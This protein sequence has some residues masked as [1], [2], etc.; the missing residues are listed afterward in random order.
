MTKKKPA[1]YAQCWANCLGDC[2]D[3]MS[4]EH[5][6]SKCL[7][8][9]DIK[10][11]GLP[12]CKD[13]EKTMRIETLTSR[14][15]CRYH[16]RSL[17]EVDNAAKHTLD[18]LGAAFELM[19]ARKNIRSRNWTVKYFETNML[20][21]ERWCLKTLININLSNKPGL[22]VDL[23]GKSNRPTEELVRIAFGLERFTPP[24]GLYRV[25][26]SGEKIDLLDGAIRLE[27]QSVNDRLAGAKFELWG[28]PFVLSLY[29]EPI[30]WE[31]CHLIRG[32]LKQWFNTY[33]LKRRPVK[34]HLVTFTY[35]EEVTR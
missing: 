6:V 19:E 7:Y 21:L 35:P 9:G 22:P 14:F 15:L 23:E 34:S 26:V 25:A 13:A 29:P 10:V 27:T 4:Q 8:K 12:W 17:S 5:L 28:I 31:G 11:K 1:D 32:E 33:D 30:K 24:K 2:A 16:N 20:L 18:T 3:G